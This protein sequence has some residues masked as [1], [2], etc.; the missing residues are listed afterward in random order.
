MTTNAN[1]TTPDASE[2][3]ETLRITKVQRRT[4]CGGSWVVGTIAG[5]R[6]DALVFPEH[7]EHPDFELAGSRISKLWLKHIE[8]QT[9]AANFDRGWDIRPTTPT[10]AAIVDVLV[11]GLTEHVFGN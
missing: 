6:F 3:L 11:A 1:N 5:H 9:T 10:A 2:I 4:S 7:A 8:M